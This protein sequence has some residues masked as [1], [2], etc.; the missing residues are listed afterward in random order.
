MRV[1]GVSF[2]K[3]EKN[4]AW[5]SSQSFPFELWS[6]RNRELALHYGAASSPR[7]FAPSRITVLLDASGA[8][9]LRYDKVDVGTHP[10]DVLEDCRALLGPAPSTPQEPGAE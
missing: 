2:N 3:I 7:A 6:D 10:G 8:L 9:L 4:R 1:V 5:A